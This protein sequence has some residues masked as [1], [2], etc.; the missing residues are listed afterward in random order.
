MKRIAALFV[1]VLLI[2][3]SAMWAQDNASAAQ[4][5]AQ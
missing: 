1:M 5:S 2:A 3:P 4:P